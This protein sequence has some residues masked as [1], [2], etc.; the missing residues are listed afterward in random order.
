M[1]KDKTISLIKN[2]LIYQFLTILHKGYYF[3]IK[4]FIVFIIVSLTKI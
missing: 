3:Y 1:N 2:D 4:L